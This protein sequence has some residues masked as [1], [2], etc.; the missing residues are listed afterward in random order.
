MFILRGASKVKVDLKECV[1]VFFYV[2]TNIVPVWRGSR[3][4]QHDHE[5]N[6]TE[7]AVLQAVM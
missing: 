7:N 5:E 6:R 3:V 2:K 4:L 1:S